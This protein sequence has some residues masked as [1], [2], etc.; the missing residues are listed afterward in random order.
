M[1]GDDESDQFEAQ[2]QANQLDRILKKTFK[3]HKKSSSFK[4]NFS[5]K[6]SLSVAFSS[7]NRGAGGGG[8]I[9]QDPSS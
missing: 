8:S 1:L 7:Q 2:Q 3:I 9:N 4:S 5:D 6:V